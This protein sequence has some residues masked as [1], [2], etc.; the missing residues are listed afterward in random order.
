MKVFL[1]AIALTISVFAQ[2]PTLSTFHKVFIDKMDNNLDQYLRAEFT[3]Q[4]KG[5]VVVVLNST[6]ADAILAGVGEQETGT[7]AK[8]TGRYLG[9]HDVATGTVS[10]LDKEG[11]VILWS[12]E[13]GDRNMWVGPLARGGQRKVADRLVSKLKKAMGY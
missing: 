4:F 2:T 12:G 11:K 1:V 3:N 6:D 5:K 10:L 8:I 7:G 13:A 9:L